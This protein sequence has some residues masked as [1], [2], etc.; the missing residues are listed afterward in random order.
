MI[1][2]HNVSLTFWLSCV[3]QHAFFVCFFF[4]NAQ[5]VDNF[6]KKGAILNCHDLSLL[7]SSYEK[8]SKDK[9]RMHEITTLNQ[10]VIKSNIL[11][12]HV[13]DDNGDNAIHVLFKNIK[14]KYIEFK[15]KKSLQNDNKYRKRFDLKATTTR[16]KRT[17]KMDSE[18]NG[19]KTL[20]S[21]CSS[22]IFSTNKQNNT[23][24]AMLF[25]NWGQPGDDT[26]TILANDEII[27]IILTF[28]ITISTFLDDKQRM[29]S[30]EVARVIFARDA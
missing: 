10:V 15:N 7:P 29:Y 19:L 17:F 27:N 11:L 21:T 26:N 14:R 24:L 12:E 9:S 28:L 3:A 13:C 4:A 25:E 20:V 23:P 1:L 2:F 18:L 6:V 16:N 30:I 8:A 5:I 22:W